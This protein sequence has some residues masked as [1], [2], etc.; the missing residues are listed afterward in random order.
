M[1]TYQTSNEKLRVSN[2]KKTFGSMDII[3]DVSFYASENEFISLLGP[4]GS[5]KSTIFNII[6]GLLLQDSGK[7]IIDGRECHGNIEKVSYM[8]QKDLLLPWKNIVDNTT[9]S[10]IIKGKSKK[11]A[12]AEVLT[13]F[14]TFGLQGFEYKYPFQLS[15]G[16]RQRAA[17][18]RTYMSSSDIMLLDE[19]FGA[20]D[21]IT[22]SKMHYWLID[23]IKELKA[24]IIFITH[25]I[26]EAI[27]LSDR[28]YV[29]SDKP[30]TIKK[31]IIVD[32]PK[33]RTA[34]IVTSEKFNEIKRI[35]LQTL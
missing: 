10:L 33:N 2:I 34:D 9:L 28:I 16:M 15:G 7:I 6:S 12:R 35:I 24:T 13:H 21:A 30:A 11:E 32:L 17:L 26:E 25:D 4:S 5:G 23:V 31:E 27:F 18:L 8:H 19:P 20:L 22:R 1:S 3:N 14:K 29:L